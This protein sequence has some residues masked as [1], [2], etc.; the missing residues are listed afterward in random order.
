MPAEVIQDRHAEPSNKS[1]YNHTSNTIVT[2][3]L[4]YNTEVLVDLTD[5]S[6]DEI[7]KKFEQVIADKKRK[8]NQA[9]A[10]ESLFR[11]DA[12]MAVETIVKNDI[13]DVDAFLTRAR[14]RLTTAHCADDTKTVESYSLSLNDDEGEGGEQEEERLENNNNSRLRISNLLN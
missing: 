14:E 3:Y 7:A 5:L 8:S 13:S 6:E 2:H 4:P 11:C 10:L 9:V 12:W 1:K